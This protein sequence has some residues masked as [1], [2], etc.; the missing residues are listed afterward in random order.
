MEVMMMQRSGASCN[1]LATVCSPDRTLG[2]RL[3][4]QLRES[5]GW[6]RS[7]LAKALRDTAHTV[8]ATSAGA[9]A[10]MSAAASRTHFSAASIQRTIARWERVDERTAPGEYYQHLLGLLFGRTP[11]GAIDLGADSDFGTLLVALH[12]FG[13]SAE[14][15]EQLTALVTRA[16]ERSEREAG[17]ERDWRPPRLVSLPQFDAAR[18]PSRHRERNAQ[19]GAQNEVLLPAIV[20]ERLVTEPLDGDTVNDTASGATMCPLNRRSAISCGLTA[21]A[22]AALSP[23]DA[24]L[25]SQRSAAPAIL[26]ISPTDGSWAVAFPS[27]PRPSRQPGTATHGPP[28]RGSPRRPSRPP[29]PDRRLRRRRENRPALRQLRA[30]TP[31]HRNRERR[32]CRARTQCA[33]NKYET[34]VR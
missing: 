30:A 26:G 16:T 34:M 28:P 5:R 11:A 4:R 21:A 7:D 25:V 1:L 20:N 29:P 27:L 9:R 2:V 13:V 19:N 31:H 6:S 24:V 32:G 14:R 15:I 18:P 12:H 8:A 3:F 10:M 22:A 17:A 23:S 33:T